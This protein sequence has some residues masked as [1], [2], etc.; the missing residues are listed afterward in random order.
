MPTDAKTSAPSA[1]LVTHIYTADPSAHVF[2]HIPDTI[3]IYPSH[4]RETD[5]TFN[6]SGDQYDMTDY[7]VISTS[8]APDA[9][10]T[11]QGVDHG[12]ALSAKDVPWVS[13][14]MWAPDAAYNAQTGKYHLFFPA[15]DKQGRFRLGVAVGDK[16]EGP[17]VPQP[18]PMQGSYSIDPAS[19]VDEDG[20]CYVYFGGIWGGE[21]QCYK[22]VQPE[23]EGD[24][25]ES[26]IGP[27]EPSG[28]GVKALGPRVGRL[29][30]DM[31][32][33]DAEGVR[34]I[35]ILAPE[36]GEEIDAD[37]HERR[38]FEASWLHRREDGKYVFSYSTGDTHFICYAVG[39]GPL[40]PFTYEGKL[41]EPVVGWTNH[42]S[43]VKYKGRWFVFYH[44]CELSKGVSHLR[45]VRVREVTW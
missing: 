14:Q 11:A 8:F 43:V 13:K 28:K 25:D 38:F 17:F 37:D 42:H 19:F 35:K 24:F 34:E 44:D 2:P 18:E 41:L 22:K 16:P 9:V 1:P 26:Q 15:R 7:H 45:T 3:Y 31:L 21:L 40:G 23:G 27:K 30:E 36:T 5:I 29:R 10:T 12:V 33:F 32:E 20:S 4:D 6:D 39:D